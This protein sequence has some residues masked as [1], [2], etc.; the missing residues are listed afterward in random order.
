MVTEIVKG[1]RRAMLRLS[2][3]LHPQTVAEVVP[4]QAGASDRS[5]RIRASFI[6]QGTR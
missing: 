1:I 6:A 2:L 3:R 4:E 5:A